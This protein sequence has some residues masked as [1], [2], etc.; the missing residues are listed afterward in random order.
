[1]CRMIF[2]A[3]MLLCVLFAQAQLATSHTESVRTPIMIVNDDWKAPA[4]IEL[5]SNDV[6][7]FSFDEMS[8][9]YHRYVCRITHHN[10]D[11]TISELAEVDYLDGFNDFV[12]DEWENSHNTTQLYTHYTFA[13]PN[14]DI[15]LKVS[16]NYRVS[17]FDEAGD[18]ESPVVTFGFSVVEPKVHIRAKVSSD[19]D[20]TYNDGEQ[21]LSFVVNHARCDVLSP[22]TELIPV[23][24][25]NRRCD[26]VVVG[27]KPTYIKGSEVEYVHNEK[28]IFEAGNEY[29]R[30]ELTDP[31]SPGINVEDVVFHDSAYHALLYID[32]PRLSYSNVIDE[33]G[34]FYV[35]TLEG[36]GMPIEADYV[37]VH[38]AI[39]MPYRAGGNLYLIGDFCNSGFN[40]NN[41]LLYDKDEGYYFASHLLKLGVYNYQYVWLPDGSRN[42]TA[43]FSEGCYHNTEN[44]YLIYIYYR[45]FG[46]RYDKLVGFIVLS[47][48]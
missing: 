5:G 1:M 42:A 7:R 25:Q 12:I 38:F 14:E 40:K 4:V 21:Q 28:L 8:H 32:K 41:L 29:R 15:T 11:G 26:N 22:E 13:L 10:L 31:N 35:N 6:V 9:V 37:N 48:N 46:A 3:I 39:D 2:T 18:I 16:G 43:C 36:Y 24:F 19:T 30:F 27:V 47:N 23:I 45:E 33:N 17:V 20:R 44:E 34:R